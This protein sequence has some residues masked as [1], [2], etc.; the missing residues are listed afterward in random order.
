[1]FWIVAAVWL[2]VMVPGAYFM[3]ERTVSDMFGSV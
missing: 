1:M 3:L 2:V